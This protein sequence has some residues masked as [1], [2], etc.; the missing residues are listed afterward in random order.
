V[1]TFFKFSFSAEAGA[2]E[3]LEVPEEKSLPAG[4]ED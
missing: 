4:R 1:K 3:A 2:L